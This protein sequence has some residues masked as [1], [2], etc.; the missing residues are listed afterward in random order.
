[1]SLRRWILVALATTAC[2]LAHAQATAPAGEGAT[3]EGPA[4]GA[5]K[6]EATDPPA[7]KRRLKFRGDRPTCT[8]A[9]ALGEGDIEAAEAK[10]ATEPQTR[11]SEK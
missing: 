1:M 9:S 7:P 2:A 10:K 11:R 3:R 6:G 5:P 4:A 8:C